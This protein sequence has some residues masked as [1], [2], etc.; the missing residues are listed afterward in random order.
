MKRWC[1][2]RKVY[3]SYCEKFII[4]VALFLHI[5]QLDDPG[6]SLDFLVQKTSLA[7]A[8]ENQWNVEGVFIFYNQSI[9]QS[10][11]EALIKFTTLQYNTVEKRV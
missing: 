11:K 3:Q 1:N 4:L 9:N 8:V 2:F 5:R 7:L 6:L 10:I